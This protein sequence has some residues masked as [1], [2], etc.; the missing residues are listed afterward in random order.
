MKLMSCIFALSLVVAV[1]AHAQEMSSM[2]DDYS[3]IEQQYQSDDLYQQDDSATERVF[4]GGRPG[5]PGHGNP[6]HG[7]P[8]I[9]G[10]GGPGP[11]HG[12]IAPGHGPGP[13]HGPIAPPPHGPIA[14]GH[15]GPGHNDHGHFGGWNPRPGWHGGWRWDHGYRRPHWWYVGIAIPV[16][17]WA[18]GIAHGYWQCTAYNGD[19][20]SYTAMGTDVNQA[21]YN[22]M[23]DCGGPD[24]DARGCYIPDGYCNFYR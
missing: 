8:I 4:P 16:F 9:P 12:P 23:Y 5:G 22:A 14:P 6:G 11:G 24:A 7:G 17:A 20:Y 15:G 3:A 1:K 13:G 21:A 18:P 10:H 2:N 19:L